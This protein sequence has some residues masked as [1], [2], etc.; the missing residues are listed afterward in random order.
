MTE[1]GKAEKLER[2]FWNNVDVGE[3]SQCWEWQGY[4]NSRGYGKVQFRVDGEKAGER[5]HRVALA[6]HMQTSLPT[7][8]VV[9]H[10]CNNPSCVNPDHL[11]PG[12]QAQNIRDREQSGNTAKG[13]SNGRAKLSA[14]EIEKIRLEYS[15]HVA[16]KAE[17]LG[18]SEKLI[19]L[20]HQGDVWE[21]LQTAS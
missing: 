5:A 14:Q 8:V 3:Q 2:R 17:E 15:Q 21:H 13:Q 1:L 19:R 10:Q 9:R 11:L 20:V 4:C 12:T 18:V 7:D 6:L 16:E